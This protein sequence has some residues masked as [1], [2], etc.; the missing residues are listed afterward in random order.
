MG[1]GAPAAGRLPEALAFALAAAGAADGAE[2]L[3][4]AAVPGGR[5]CGGREAAP[6]S[7]LPVEGPAGADGAGVFLVVFI[8]LERRK[9]KKRRKV[10][11]SR[12]RISQVSRGRSG[13]TKVI[14][15]TPI[16]PCRVLQP[17]SQ[18]SSASKATSKVEQLVFRRVRRRDWMTALTGGGQRSI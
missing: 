5:V 4:V 13:C 7:R 8:F 18:L 2:V 15:S 9:T 10:I 17:L 16:P 1:G 12:L 14:G 6:S 11:F 3:G